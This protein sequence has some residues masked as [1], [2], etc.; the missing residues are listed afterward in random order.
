MGMPRPLTP[1][2]RMKASGLLKAATGNK[3]TS[4][5]NQ[6]ELVYYAPQI[7]NGTNYYMVF[8]LESN[9]QA[10]Y[11]CVTVYEALPVYGGEIEMTNFEKTTDLTA[12]CKACKSFGEAETIC[13]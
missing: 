13:Q 3:L 12:A 10:E 6:P 1:D 8:E 4:G 9:K 7:V 5:A 11:Y 2:V